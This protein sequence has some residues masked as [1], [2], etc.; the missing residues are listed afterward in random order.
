V[1]QRDVDERAVRGGEQLIAVVQLAGD[2]DPAAGVVLEPGR[3]G[4]R[5]VDV[6]GPAVADRES[7]GNRGK[8]IPGRKQPA[9]L[10]E[11]RRYE[12]A[13]RKARPS[14]MFVTERERRLV[15]RQPLAVGRR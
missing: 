14:L 7:G 10:V 1:L 12:A 15:V 6:Y 9:G 4:Q 2:L 3:N 13:V 11:R 5:P 8:P